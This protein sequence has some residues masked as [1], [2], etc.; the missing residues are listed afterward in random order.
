MVDRQLYS[1]TFSLVV[2][3]PAS[4]YLEEAFEALHFQ[5]RHQVIKKVSYFF[6]KFLTI[7]QKPLENNVCSRNELN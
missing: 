4:L 5:H 7:S 2:L 6:Q 1:Y 3:A